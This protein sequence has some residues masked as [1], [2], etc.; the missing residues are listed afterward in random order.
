MK[1]IPMME[2]LDWTSEEYAPELKGFWVH[3]PDAMMFR[4]KG[5]FKS[6]ALAQGWIKKNP[7]WINEKEHLRE[8]VSN[9]VTEI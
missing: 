5:P 9:A 7:G 8:M 2:I 1:K 6:K 4:Y 3:N